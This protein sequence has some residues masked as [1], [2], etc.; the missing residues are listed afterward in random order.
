MKPWD[1]LGRLNLDNHEPCLTSGPLGMDPFLVII[2]IRWFPRDLIQ[3]MR[4][5]ELTL[6]E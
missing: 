4:G 1:K 2:V 5:K 3:S 6:N